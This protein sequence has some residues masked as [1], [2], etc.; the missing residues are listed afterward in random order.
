MMVKASDEVM[1]FECLLPL[2]A[3]YMHSHYNLSSLSCS[4]VHSLLPPSSVLLMPCQS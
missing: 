3:V 4:P 2:I 1:N